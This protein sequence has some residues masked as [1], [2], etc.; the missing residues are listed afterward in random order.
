MEPITKEST[1]ALGMEFLHFPEAEVK[2]IKG[3]DSSFASMG[4]L[5]VLY[6]K[7]YHRFVLQINDWRYPLLRRMPVIGDKEEVN[8]R[9][10]VLPAP[11]GF[12]F[13]LKISNIANMS[14]LTNFETI[15]YNNSRFSYKGEEMA[16]RNAEESPDDKVMRHHGKDQ[17]TGLK[18]MGMEMMKEG[19]EK[20][21]AKKSTMNMG[22][23]NL[24]SKNRRMNLKE[25]TNKD[26]QMEAKSHFKKGF[27]E[28]S[29]RKTQEF[30]KL[31]RENYNM[32][33]VLDYEHLMKVRETAKFYVE[34]NEIEE[35][36]MRSKD[37]ADNYMMKRHQEKK[38][39]M[40]FL[41]QGIHDI[42]ESISGMMNNRSGRVNMNEGKDSKELPVPEGLAHSEG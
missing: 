37:L 17:K 36:I 12:S 42:K 22:T 29:R 40:D 31:R 2:K 10:Y 35:M 5:S 39:I 28:D 9:T 8:S 24:T 33:Q 34:K 21:K 14:A 7:D 38:G 13:I 16:P 6:F 23:M 20:I 32:T 1:K 26:S 15:L 3:N 25:I 41:K 4:H 11:N 27:F 30:Y 18:E 19:L